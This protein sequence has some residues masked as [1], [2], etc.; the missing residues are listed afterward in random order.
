M[1]REIQV[2]VDQIPCLVIVSD[3]SQA[4]LEAKAA[5]R[6]IIAVEKD[7][8]TLPSAPYVVPNWEDVS[9]SWQS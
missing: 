9:W 6:A 7:G 3:E 1:T 4:L 2:T 8:R 5:G